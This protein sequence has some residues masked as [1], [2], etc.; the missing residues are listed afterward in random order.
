M[1][2]VDT[3]VFVVLN[4]LIFGSL[5][6]L[7]AVGL[8]LIFGV[9]DVPNFAQGEFA[10][11]SGFVTLALMAAGLSLVPSALGGLLAAVVAGVVVERLIISK[12]YGREE[13]LLL[14]FFVT[15]G[16]VIIAENTFRK[17]FGFEQ[18]PAPDVGTI[19]VAGSQVDVL[20]ILAGAI[21]GLLLVGLYVFTR[22]S[23]AG[24]AMRAVASD[25]DGSQMVG[26]DPG[27]MF[28]LT[29]ALGALLSGLTGILYGMLFTLYPTLGVRLTAFAFTIVVVGGVGSF[30][31]AIVASLLIGLID[32]VTASLIGSR[33]R[34]FAVFAILFLV[35]A[36]KPGGL[37][38]GDYDRY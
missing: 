27:Q 15:V 10:T 16:L 7:A 6:A 20:Q 28:T 34:F 35:L 24:L 3:A 38:G 21:A 37:L 30:P 33:Y 31:G 12:L 32:S 8:S 13:F 36:L 26:I 9:L 4:G 22:R 17:L 19:T 5:L 29:F 18:I 25:R 1:S 14:S 23:Y 2:A 11:L